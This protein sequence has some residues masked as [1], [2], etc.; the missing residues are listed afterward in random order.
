MRI[1]SWNIHGCVGADGQHDPQ[2][3]ARALASMRP[4]IVALQE[5]NGVDA[6]SATAGNDL[7][8]IARR[9]GLDVAAGP[10]RTA[11]EGYFGNAILTRFK[12]DDVGVHDIS[13]PGR[14]PRAV[15]SA[16]IEGPART[17]QVLVTH[18]G[19]AASERLQQARLL[20]ALARGF[21][22][23]PSI[24]AGDFNEWRPRARTMSLLNSTLG[25][26]AAPR[27]FPSRLPLF[28][29]DRIW[30]NP[31]EA[32]HS[33]QRVKTPLVRLA[34]DHLPVLVETSWSGPVRGPAGT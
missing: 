1:V 25:R 33:L 20:T 30:V 28:R 34:S 27:T 3:V 26:S 18:F 31:V 10:A 8:V 17:V 19:L 15:L 16:R 4:D 29:L 32:L 11:G 24:V 5:V 21:S 14:E 2:R 23:G 7:Q 12:I 13:V 9:L 22:A 6:S